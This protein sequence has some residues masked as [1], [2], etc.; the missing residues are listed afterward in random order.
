VRGLDQRRPWERFPQL[1]AQVRSSSGYTQGIATRDGPRQ[2]GL[3]PRVRALDAVRA[4]PAAAGNDRQAGRLLALL[5]RRNDGVLLS[6]TA[7]AQHIGMANE[8]GAIG[9]LLEQLHS[10]G[11]IRLHS[12]VVGQRT[13]RV[14]TLRDARELR[15]AMAP[16][17]VG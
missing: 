14:V 6:P 8:I 7:L 4:A 2:I 16:E 1:A 10:E 12:G 11:R 3:S 17:P 13:W 15:S 5:E 9:A